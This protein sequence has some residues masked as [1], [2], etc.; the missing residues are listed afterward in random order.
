MKKVNVC[1][2]NMFVLPQ[3]RASVIKRVCSFRL[4]ISGAFSNRD[5]GKHWLLRRCSRATRHTSPR[6]TRWRGAS[7]RAKGRI[8][9][10]GWSSLASA[11]PTS[12]SSRAGS[13]SG[14]GSW[15][16]DFVF[17]Y[18]SS[19]CVTWPFFERWLEVVLNFVQVRNVALWNKGSRMLWYF[20]A[21]KQRY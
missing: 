10:R 5:G 8:A 21:D 14:R 18:Q 19:S 15:R 16:E 11:P 12:A 17:L 1:H 7:W 6:R 13:T 4:L 9:S 3:K 20:G 2:S